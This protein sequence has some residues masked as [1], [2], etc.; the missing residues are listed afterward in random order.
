MTHTAKLFYT[1]EHEWIELIN[2][3]YVRIGITAY[4]VEQLGDIVFVELPELNTDLSEEDEFATVESVKSTSEIF[5]PVGGTV[6]KVNS[7]LEDEPEKM[8]ESP[9]G[10]GWLIELQSNQA[11][12]TS[13][14]LDEKAYQDYLETL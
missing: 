11:V 12:D 4:A 7:S 13:H 5:A 9:Y 14:L 8:N 2:E 1:K 10:E 3:D 6:S